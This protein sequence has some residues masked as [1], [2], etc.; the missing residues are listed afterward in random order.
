[1]FSSLL[2]ERLVDELFLTLAPKLTGGGTE[3]T[4]STGMELPELG[5]LDP[6]WVL[7][8]DGSLY[9]RY[10]VAYT[11]GSRSHGRTRDLVDRQCAPQ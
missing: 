8:R 11:A 5:A 3:P 4:I 1:M 6:A 7:E 10:A 9:L 2:T